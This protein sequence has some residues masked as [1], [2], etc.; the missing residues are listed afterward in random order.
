M[1]FAVRSLTVRY[2]D[3]SDA[4]LENV[5]CDIPTGQTTA[6]LGL[7]GS[8]KTTL[9]NVLGLLWE[10]RLSANNVVYHG[11]Y[12][13][14]DY[15]ELTT[16][17]K[18]DLRQYEFGFVLQSAYLLSHFSCLDNIAMPLVT[19]GADLRTRRE[20][21]KQLLRR[22]DPSCQLSGLALRTGRTLSGG[23]KQRIAL[24]RAVIHDPEVVFADEPTSNLDFQSA[25]YIISLLRDWQAGRL[26][27]NQ[28][29]ARRRTLIFVSHSLETAYDLADSFVVLKRGKVVKDRALAKSELSNASELYRLVEHGD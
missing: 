9:L 28:G 24:L 14:Q 13:R 6:V 8:G 4:A 7:S 16:A 11:R 23:Q 27:E 15:R 25:G 17:T 12:G 29:E 10:D 19:H 18:D 3:Q 20:R 21:A 2:Q 22:A 1:T 26:S 5:S